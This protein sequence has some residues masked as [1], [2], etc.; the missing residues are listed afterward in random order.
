MAGRGGNPYVASAS[1]EASSGLKPAGAARY[2][3]TPATLV[4]TVAD[5]T[6]SARAA[7]L[8][9]AVTVG[10]LHNK[11]TAMAMDITAIVLHFICRSSL[12]FALF[13]WLMVLAFLGLLRAWV[14]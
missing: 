13:C 10:K 1:S 6:Y 9:A 12:T 8:C 2:V 5:V 14:E 7:S 11:R 3:F 4:G